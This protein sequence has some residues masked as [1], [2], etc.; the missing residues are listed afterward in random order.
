[1]PQ[2]ESIGVNAFIDPV[3][4]QYCSRL[5][6]LN[7][8]LTQVPGTDY[9]SVPHLPLKCLSINH[10]IT[11][12][13]L[14]Q[15][16]GKFTAMQSLTLV[17]VKDE[18]VAHFTDLQ[19]LT[20]LVVKNSESFTGKTLSPFTNMQVLETTYYRGGSNEKH[21]RALNLPYLYSIA[22]SY[23]DPFG[24]FIPTTANSTNFNDF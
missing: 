10:A 8:L 4:F 1:M 16:I 19:Q 22:H 15:T 2:L 5:T 17:G 21:V 12:K 6:A 7:C 18:D 23:V 3:D 9:T 14:L 20:R 24:T 11:N 13:A